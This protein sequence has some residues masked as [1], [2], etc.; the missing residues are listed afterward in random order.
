MGFGGGPRD[1][2]LLPVDILQQDP[3]D[4]LDA[5]PVGIRREIDP[6][7]E[8]VVAEPGAGPVRGSA[9]IEYGRLDP[10]R[11]EAFRRSLLEIL[12]E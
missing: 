7:A 4:I 5:L 2:I 9:G 8:E 6:V 11:F 3:R 10:D 12:D 1:V